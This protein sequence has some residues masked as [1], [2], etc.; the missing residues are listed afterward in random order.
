[1]RSAVLG[2]L[3]RASV[4][5]FMAV[6]E[7]SRKYHGTRLGQFFVPTGPKKQCADCEMAKIEM[8]RCGR[9]DD[10]TMWEHLLSCKICNKSEYNALAVHIIFQI[11]PSA[12]S[13]S[14]TICK[15]SF[16]CGVCC[17]EFCYECN[18]EW[19]PCSRCENVFCLECTD[20]FVCD[21]CDEPFCNDC[22]DMLV[23]CQCDKP[24]WCGDCK[25]TSIWTCAD[26]D[27]P[28][29]GGCALMH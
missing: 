13:N 5:S 21:G 23:C 26:C 10:F 19:L 12:T 8:V 2:F 6:E 18:S 16:F 17:M 28:L 9:C 25:D 29:C 20:M 24:F 11:A 27:K 4:A 3:D 7:F 14:A 22:T 1:M 15:D